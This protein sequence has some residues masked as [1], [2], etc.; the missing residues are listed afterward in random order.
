[1]AE[2]NIDPTV[3]KLTQDT[4]GKYVKKPPLSEKLLKKPPFRFLFDIFTVLVYMLK[5]F[6]ICNLFLFQLGQINCPDCPK[7][8]KTQISYERHIFITHSES[9]EF[10]CSIC[11]AKLRTANLLKLHE[12]QH[13]NRGKPYACK[14]CGKD[15]TRTYHLKRHQKYTS[16]SANANDT[17]SC[18]VCNK[19]FYRL[20]NLRAHLK[21]HLGT[22]VTKKEE[23]MCPIC[24]NCFYSLSTLNIHTRTHTGERPF[25]CD[26]CDKKFPSLVA[27][28][29]HRR[30]HTGEK[31]YTCPECNQS[32][33]VKEVLNRHMKRHTGE[34]PHV[35]PECGKSFIQATQ[36]RCHSKTHIRPFGCDQCE[37][38]FKTMKQLER[39][40]KIHS[41]KRKR[42]NKAQEHKFKCS[43]C[44]ATYTTEEEL[45]THYDV[46]VHI[47]T[48][49]SSSIQMEK[50]RTD[51]AVCDKE[52]DSL[53][54]LNSHILKV[55]DEK[56]ETFHNAKRASKVELNTS[57][58]SPTKIYRI[59]DSNENPIESI[60]TINNNDILPVKNTDQT[61]IEGGV[62]VQQFIV[63][64]VPESTTEQLLLENKLYTVIPLE[65]ET[66]KRESKITVPQESPKDRK[67]N[68]KSL[69]ES[70]VAAITD[71][72]SD[73]EGQLMIVENVETEDDI[74]VKG[75]V[76]RL[77][78]ILVDRSTLKK[79]G[80]PEATEEYVLCKV[81]ENC[82]YDLGKDESCNADSDYA[83]RMREYVK[84]LFSVVIHNDSIKELLNNY[85]IDDVIEFVLDNDD[86]E[87]EEDDDDEDD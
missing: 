1:M 36:L 51:C 30:Y 71:D 17:M 82:G 16:C 53:K 10:P 48:Y 60:T 6:L 20:D 70:L 7:S 18:K 61:S 64:E 35:C 14:I 28:K 40:T 26:L 58:S 29:K 4:L 69:A 21:H 22:Q 81:I 79:F 32:F 52:F 38:K 59:D 41:S 84:L 39:H 75:N 11:N 78:D 27:L 62:V 19:V 85:P 66:M 76:R 31:P 83:T 50:G 57:G 77:L 33:A 25:A 2:S 65:N 9:D 37:E 87:R 56:P 3:I 63:D 86:H 74:R 8:F 15:F 49:T 54:T 72:V 46:G 73:D 42:K 67:R 45:K 68:I 12:E 23:Y 80:W 13:K 43:E 47:P 5:L 24:K 55:H 44:K 34:K